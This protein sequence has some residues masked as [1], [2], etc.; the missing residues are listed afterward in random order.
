MCSARGLG[1]PITP[2]IL[3]TIL[4]LL[5]RCRYTAVY[6]HL[7]SVFTPWHI[8]NSYDADLAMKA[9]NWALQLAKS[10]K[11]TWRNA[12]RRIFYCLRSTSSFQTSRNSNVW[13]I[14]KNLIRFR[15]LS[16]LFTLSEN[17]WP[18]RL[19]NISTTFGREVVWK[20]KKQGLC[21]F[22]LQKSQMFYEVTVL[23]LKWPLHVIL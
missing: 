3:P 1:L 13:S 15:K 12:K 4:S 11:L 14:F 16:Y 5:I 20:S 19:K 10:T 9:T 17:Y 6:L 2:F 22:G 18:Q 7:D 23:S 8:V 21:C